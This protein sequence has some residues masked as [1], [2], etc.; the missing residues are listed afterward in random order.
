MTGVNSRILI[1]DDELELCL[2]LKELLTDEGFHCEYETDPREVLPLL[3]KNDIALVLLDIRMPAIGGIDLLKIL[4]SRFPDLPVIIISGHATVDTAVRAMKHGAVNLFTKPL[5]IDS[6][7][8]EMSRIIGS[9]KTKRAVPGNDKLITQSPVMQRILDLV[10]KA[11]PTDATVLITGESGTG[12]ELIA[13]LLHRLSPRNSSP[14][15][16][17]NCA[18]ISETLLESEIFG[19][20]Q[21]AFT[22][23]KQRKQGYFEA[24][25][26]GTIFLDEIGDMSLHTQAKMLRVLQERQF[27]RVGGTELIESDVR[28]IAAT[29]KNLRECIAE[30][31]FR[32]D[33]FYRLTVI[34]LHLPPLRERIE[35]ILPLAD[36]FLTFFNSVYGKSITGF[37]PSVRAFLLEHDWPGNIRELKNFVERAVIFCTK[38]EISTDM[39]PDQY[40]EIEDLLEGTDRGFRTEDNLAERYRDQ[41]REVI[42]EALKKTRGVKKEAAELLKID[43]KTLY[44]R[45]KRFNIE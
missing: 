25:G 36:Y 12:K 31:S 4:R 26:G 19:H 18:A 45:M 43:R 32:E 10:R 16:R 2:S 35:D 9:M 24:A 3:E 37:D 5:E 6:L 21:G 28:V 1:V 29:N 38:K 42:L 8:S 39:V 40:R 34:N 11:A 27:T 17:V 7:V 15:I 30:G 23:A 14:N 20:E 44:N 33:L 22:D 13:G 41:G